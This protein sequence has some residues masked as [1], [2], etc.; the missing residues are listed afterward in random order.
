MPMLI[1]LWPT[2]IFILSSVCNNF[3][4]L[5]QA[6][7]LS[8]HLDTNGRRLDTIELRIEDAEHEE[9]EGVRTEKDNE[10]VR[11]FLDNSASHS[12]DRIDLKSGFYSEPK[13]SQSWHHLHHLDH[14][15]LKGRIPVLIT[16]I[17]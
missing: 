2:F 8:N 3:S 9:G 6:P 12:V 11:N 16:G 14:Q 13:P 7:L 15:D 10:R 17:N 4:S 5:F 1:F